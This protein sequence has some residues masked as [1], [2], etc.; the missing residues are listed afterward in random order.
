MNLGI[1][2]R[3]AGQGAPESSCLC[4][5]V[6][7]FQEHIK[8]P[9]FL[10][11]CAVLLLAEEVLYSLNLFDIIVYQL[12]LKKIKMLVRFIYKQYN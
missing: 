9:G 10:C 2:I 4:P 5:P 3:L 7:A 1:S 11:R 6:L 12:K 8:I